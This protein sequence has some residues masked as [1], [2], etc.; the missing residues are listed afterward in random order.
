MKRMLAVVAL[1]M[2]TLTRGAAQVVGSLPD[3]SPFTDLDGG[4]RFGLI[5]GYLST[6]TDVV[7]VGPK[8]GPLVG[9][10]YDLSVGGPV[11]LTG[12]LFGVSTTRTI[13]DYTRTAATRDVGEQSSEL[14]NFN[15]AMAMSLTGKRSWHRLQPLVNIGVGVV[16]AAGDKPDISGYTFGTNFSFSYGLG[17]RYA[18]GHNSE[19]RLDA[20]WYWWQIKYPELYR[21]TQGDPIA[22]RPTGQLNSYTDNR[23][24]TL[25]WTVRGF[26]RIFH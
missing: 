5:G 11:Y 16:T 1:S 19:L 20:N 3:K 10:R 15:V 24:V 6:G 7:G 18:T 17:L 23:A 25:G 13:L 14:V 12:T 26:T 9:I 21:S 4:Q 8:S 2:L 22:I